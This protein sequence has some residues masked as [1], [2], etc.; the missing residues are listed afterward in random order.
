MNSAHTLQAVFTENPTTGK[1][2]AEGI[3]IRDSSG[4]LLKL[5]GFNIDPN[6]FTSNDIQWIK[7]RGYNSIRLNMKWSSI[8]PGKGQYEWSSLDDIL[9]A[10]QSSGVWAI[11]DFQQW[12]WSPYFT[13]GSKP[14]AGGGVGFPTWLME[15]GGY[16]N[17]A[18]GQQQAYD[19]F[20]LK[21]DYGATTWQ[22]FTQFWTLVVNRYK[23]NPWVLGYEVINEPMV[24]S[25]HINEARTACMDRYR[26][27]IPMM[28]SLDPNTIII[29]HYIDNGYN[30]DIE[31]SNIVWTKSLYKYNWSP[32]NPSKLDNYLYGLKEVFNNGMQVPFIFSEIGVQPTDEEIAE[33]FLT[34]AFTRMKA[35]LN[36]GVEGWSYYQYAL[37]AKGGYQGP[38]NADGSDSWVQP[39]LAMQLE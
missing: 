31:Y 33:E 2:Y 13:F 32:T 6:K 20:Y 34:T 4:S 38:R 23:D 27:I 17:D 3:E 15:E 28:R 16:T 29:L 25:T 7:E 35:I 18:T 39:I 1:P 8:E 5:H 11:I 9:A 22:E 19:D 30:Q 24:G 12:E 26:E 14:G 21:R 10:C 37:G 36:D